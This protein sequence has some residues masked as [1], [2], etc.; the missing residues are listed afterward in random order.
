M[1]HGKIF[2]LK[3]AVIVRVSLEQMIY[4]NIAKSGEQFNV[5]LEL[6]K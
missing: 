2:L 6:G 1:G 4:I 3:I 5:H